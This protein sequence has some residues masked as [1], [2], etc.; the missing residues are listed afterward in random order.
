MA[1][2]EFAGHRGARTVV[3]G[4]PMRRVHE[5]VFAVPALEREPVEPR[6]LRQRFRLRFGP[7]A[8]NPAL[9]RSDASARR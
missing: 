9:S 8:L 4:K 6:A 2:R 7:L 1:M 5:W 3:A